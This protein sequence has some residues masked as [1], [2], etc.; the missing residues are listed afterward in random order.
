MRKLRFLISLSMEESPYQQLLAAVAQQTAPRFG[1][2]VRTIYAANDPI[3]QSDQL[4]KAIQS[5][6][7]ARPD[8][9]LCSPVGTNMVQVARHA[10]ARGIG[11]ILLNRDDDYI[12]ELRKT[13]SVP[14]FCVGM[15]QEEIGRIQGKQFGALLPEGGLVLYILGPNYSIAQRRLSGMQST[16]PADVE[17]RTLPG[18]WSE[19]SGYK[20]LSGWLKLSTS[21]NAPVALVAGQNDAMAMGARRAF[22][23]LTGPARARWV[24]LLFTGV[25]Y[26]PRAGEEW[27]GKGLLAASV[28][29][30]P[31]TGVA[32]EMF[33]RAVQANSQPP[34]N[35]LLAP[36]SCPEIYELREIPARRGVYQFLSR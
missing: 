4:L 34:I 18:N 5:P 14:V 20:A 35:T 8:A 29:Q 27:V 31:V 6:Q 17:I 22:D 11:W 21:E 16:K 7:D 15:D 1:V 10:T 9:I 13:C 33:V 30:H 26:S 12:A 28:R 36:V 32:L 2:D 19:E 25:D 24:D 3:T 23:E